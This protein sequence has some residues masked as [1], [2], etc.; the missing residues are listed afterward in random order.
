MDADFML[1]LE[2]LL[3]NG[4]FA[5][6]IEKLSELEEDDLTPDL[7]ITL[8]HSLSQC[9]RF[10]DSLEVLKEINDEVEEDDFGY[11]LELAGAYYGLHHYNSAIKEAKK[12]IRIEEDYVDSW[13]LLA[14]IYQET[15]R[16]D[17]F[18]QASVTARELDE[19]VWNS[20]FGNHFE[21]LEEY[22]PDE[23][24]IVTDFIC[25]CFGSDAVPFPVSDNGDDGDPHPIQVFLIPPDF[26]RNYYKIISI[27]IGAYR[28]IENDEA[29]QKHVHR[30]ELCAFLPGSLTMQQVQTDYRWTARIIR[31]FGEMLELDSSWFGYG[32]T[33][34]YG[35]FL[36]KNNRFNGVIF[37]TIDDDDI[38]SDKCT[39]PCG[40]DVTF[41]QIMPLYEE[42]ML[43]KVENGHAAIFNK[44][45]SL[46]Y[47]EYYKDDFS[48]ILEEPNYLTGIDIIDINR[49]NCCYDSNEKQRLI[50]RTSIEELLDWDGADG[51]FATDRITVDG[52]KV[53]FMY[54][55]KPVE[56]Q[57]DSGW[58]FLAGD[59][60]EQYMNDMSRMDI[61]SLN[62][63]A[64]YDI[65]I[66]E[67]LDMPVGTALYRTGNGEFRIIKRK[68]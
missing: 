34:S 48:A 20:V 63:I 57:P 44:L 67:Y 41:L 39:L 43:Y 14:L 6:V 59:E 54:R 26:K 50:A 65:D 3:V 38:A 37:D 36:D 61:Y 47:H 55:E 11:H 32:H 31:Q 33:V 66:I 21:E 12:C 18:E 30:V 46:Y 25:E 4:E 23:Q 68:E 2:E 45:R 56:G 8:A 52:C 16:D 62:T 19:D 51:C 58:R 7:K 27:G 22:E 1:E 15:G 24:K 28:G 53:G 5:A 35:D 10:R 17:L 13:I 40:D 60:D 9:G 49:I 64:N 29:G 42:E